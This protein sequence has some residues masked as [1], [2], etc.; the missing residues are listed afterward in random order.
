MHQYGVMFDS[1]MQHCNEIFRA[2]TVQI[3]LLPNKKRTRKSYVKSVMN[4]KTITDSII[5]SISIKR[6]NKMVMKRKDL[7]LSLCLFHMLM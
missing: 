2:I 7:M 6:Y 4:A 5:Q 1:D 3:T